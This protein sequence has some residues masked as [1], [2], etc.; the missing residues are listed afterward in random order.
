MRDSGRQKSSTYYSQH[1]HN[2]NKTTPTPPTP[3]F[4]SSGQVVGMELEITEV[5]K[6][7]AYHCT[8]YSPEDV[9]DLVEDFPEVK[10]FHSQY[11]D[12]TTSDLPL[13]YIDCGNKIYAI[14][15]YAHDYGIDID[16]V[17]VLEWLSDDP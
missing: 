10:E 2:P 3:Y 13:G 9:D 14:T 6:I 1:Y 7:R 4:F 5:K 12:G 17:D 15:V 16:F 11:F 8:Y